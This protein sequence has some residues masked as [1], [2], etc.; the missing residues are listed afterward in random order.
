MFQSVQKIHI[1][2]MRI[3]VHHHDNSQPDTHLSS[4]YHHNKKD[5]Q[6]SVDPRIRIRKDQ[7]MLM[8]LRES[9]QQQIH[10]IQ[11]QLYTHENND[12]IAPGEDTSHPD[13]EQRY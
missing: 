8:H 13:T 1:Y 3:P 7:R 5:E 4:S 2:R 12:R 6:L 9:H 10:G 11:H